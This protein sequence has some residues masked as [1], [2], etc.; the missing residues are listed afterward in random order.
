MTALDSAN[1]YYFQFSTNYALKKLIN[2][3]QALLFFCLAIL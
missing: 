1:M 2:V 3:I